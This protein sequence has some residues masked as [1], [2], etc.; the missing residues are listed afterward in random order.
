MKPGGSDDLL[1]LL[2]YNDKGS[3]AFHCFPEEEFKY[4]FFIAIALRMLFPDERVG[5]DGKKIIPVFSRE[6]AKLDEFAFQMWL[7]IE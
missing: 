1:S 2:I 4:I 5:R 7:K 6:R 3:A